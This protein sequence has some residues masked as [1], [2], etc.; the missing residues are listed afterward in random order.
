LKQEESGR[1]WHSYQG[2]WNRNEQRETKGRKKTEYYSRARKRTQTER[3]T[4]G[5]QRLS[6]ALSGSPLRVFMPAR[7][8]KGPPR[9]QGSPSESACGYVSTTSIP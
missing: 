7:W 6:P 1:K 3:R 4:G 9:K 5:A 2:K 8:G